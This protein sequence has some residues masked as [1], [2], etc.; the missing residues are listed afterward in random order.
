M[1]LLLL[2]GR[3]VTPGRLKEGTAFPTGAAIAPF[4]QATVNS[5]AKSHLQP[6]YLSIF[7]WQ[8]FTGFGSIS[9]SSYSGIVLSFFQ[10]SF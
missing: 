5:S 9:T 10:I 4:S 2:P 1:L 6:I 8:Q 7:L 3:A